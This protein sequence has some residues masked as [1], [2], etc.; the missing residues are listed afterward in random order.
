MNDVSGPPR[1]QLG[2]SRLTL[3]DVVAQS[4]GFVGPVFSAAFI[5][6]L[7][8][9]AGASGRGAGLATPV[10]I[11]IA[12]IGVAAIGWI[13]SRYASRIAAAGSLYDYVTQGFG[14]E[15]GAI[16]GW[17][18]YGGIAMLSTAIAVFI[19]GLTSDYLASAYDVHIAYWVLDLVYIAIVFFLVYYGVRISTRAQLTLVLVSASVIFA[20]MVY[21]IVKQGGTNSVQPFNPGES[22]QGW[23]GIFYGVLYGILIFV[24]FETAANLAEETAEPRRNIPRAIYIALGVVTVYYLVVAYGQA[25]GFGLDA[26]AW[27]ESIA[28]GPIL[29]LASPDLFGSDWFFKL[30]F[31]LVILDVFAVGLGCAVATSRGIFALARDGRIPRVFARVDER[32]GTPVA[33]I[34]LG[35]VVALAFVLWVVL[36]NGVLATGGGP[37][38]FPMFS[39]LAGFGGFCL[40]LVYGLVCLAGIRGL[41]RLE[42]GP[43]L[44]AAGVIGA[45]AAAGAIW[46][47]IYKVEP[48]ASR[49]PWIALAWFALGALIVLGLRAT[50]RLHHPVALA[51]DDERLG[52]TLGPGSDVQRRP[53]SEA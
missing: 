22:S 15:V 1:E 30:V 2:E 10:A 49:I 28:N 53:V 29:V 12:A 36:D 3:L 32:R 19:G 20:F 47:A 46:G 13:I 33:A 37:E 38:Y 9:G 43:S 8:V 11:V 18:Y 50:G 39:W 14:R 45:A 24:G 5:I 31:A 4:V 23:S 35:A 40:V 6:P 16:A 41:W 21:V 52:T 27:T 25:V 34:V 17:G 26:G 42:P 48:P 7:I 51:R 44:L